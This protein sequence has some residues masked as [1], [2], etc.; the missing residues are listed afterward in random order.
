MSITKTI[1]KYQKG[2]GKNKGLKPDE[3]LASFDYCY[4]YFYSFYSTDNVK[5]MGN[6]PRIQDS[7]L[8]L[9]FYLASFGMM[10]GSSFLLEKSARNLIDTI[11]VISESEP[12]L[13]EID[14]P[15]YNE[16]NINLLLET[17]K[18]IV[19]ALG[20]KNNP[21]D[22][23]VSKIM[24]G[25]YGNVPAY[26][27]FFKKSLGVNTFNND[28]LMKIKDFY[29]KNKDEI[30]CIK[31]KTLDFLTGKETPNK[32]SKAK[33]IDMYGFIDGKRK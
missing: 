21:S 8:Q 4:N 13:W 2:D 27:Q 10:R 22:T 3:R 25:V 31:I 12:I 7:C 23:L 29:L 18:N 33:I 5:S 17:K 28:S 9:G 11:E 1:E 6:T 30:D 14:V 24:L 15:D 20:K 19:D 26:D 32:Y 16:K